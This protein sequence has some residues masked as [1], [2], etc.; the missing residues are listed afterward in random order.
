MNLPQCF[1]LY[2]KFITSIGHSFCILIDLI[3]IYLVDL[4]FGVG[5]Y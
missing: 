4:M 5:S 2:L 1:N 3:Y